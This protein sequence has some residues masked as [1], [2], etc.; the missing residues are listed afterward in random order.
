MTAETATSP[1]NAKEHGDDTLTEY[2]PA[3]EMAQRSRA[4]GNTRAGATAASQ[5]NDP[6]FNSGTLPSQYGERDALVVTRCLE[7]VQAQAKRR[8][9]EGLS[10]FA[11]FVGVMNVIV[12]T[13]L[14]SGYPEHFWILYAAEV[15]YL[16][17]KRYLRARAARCQLYW[18][19][20]CWFV[21]FIGQLMLAAVFL[22][23]RFGRRG[24]AN[25]ATSGGMWPR[26]ASAA[27]A[28]LAGTAITSS[29][30]RRI[31]GAIFGT[32]CGPLGW[33][34]LA[35]QNA[36]V[37]HSIDQMITTF[38]HIF[39]PLLCYTLRWK[40][41]AILA[42][43]P[44]VFHLG[45]IAELDIWYDIVFPSIVLYWLWWVC[46]TPFLIFY[47]VNLPKRRKLDTVFHSLMRGSGL[48][49]Q[50]SNQLA[51]KLPGG[52]KT[53]EDRLRRR[54]NNDFSKTQVFAYMLTH[55]FAVHLSFPLAIPLFYSRTCFRF[56]IFFC[57]CSLTWNAAVRYSYQMTNVFEKVIV[58][59][60]KL[61]NAEVVVDPKKKK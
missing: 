23:T 40:T 39:P 2:P 45:Y 56:F 18:L 4:G 41:E 5:N 10:P 24:E 53:M 6:I 38:I 51:K 30:R 27:E 57:T 15:V 59:Q 60:L 33:A 46:Y 49:E 1:S 36:L 8:H 35:L 34:T 37:F 14:F 50:L 61:H 54:A 22:D 48:V 20:Y 47:G 11:F 55:A 42:A 28:S 44:G 58:E 3:A 32:A 43:H 29:V 7:A 9:Q 31:F 21:N 52:P 17:P 25:Q 26:P 16:F 12:T 13:Y 19:D